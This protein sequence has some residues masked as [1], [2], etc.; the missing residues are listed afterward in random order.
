MSN[1]SIRPIDRTL[2][3]ATTPGQ[4]GP[5]SNGNQ[6]VLHIPQ[7]SRITGDSSSDCLISNPGHLS[8]KSYSTAPANWA[9]LFGVWSWYGINI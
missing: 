8:E 6:G 5:G 4:S 1:S 9:G 2:S 3:G 7:I